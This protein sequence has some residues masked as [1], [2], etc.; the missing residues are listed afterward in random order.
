[1]KFSPSLKVIAKELAPLEYISKKKLPPGVTEAEALRLFMALTSSTCP[2]LVHLV[3]YGFD[4]KSLR[5]FLS[6]YAGY[7]LEIP[8]RKTIAKNWEDLQL[9]LHVEQRLAGFPDL[10]GAFRFTATRMGVPEKRVFQ[11]YGRFTAMRVAL[12]QKDSS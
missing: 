7:R 9:W 10:P 1:M 6:T 8:S 4:L 3:D 2:M 5:A 12:P 11:A